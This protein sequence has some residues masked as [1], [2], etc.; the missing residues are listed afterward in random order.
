MRVVLDTNVLVSTLIA[1]SGAPATIYGLW[2]DRKFT[3]LISAEQIEEL[4]AVLK[5]PKV[6]MLMKPYTAGSLV[7]QL[8]RLA[9]MVDELPRVDRSPDP[10]DD[11]L[12]ALCEAGDADYL[13]TGDKRGLL[14]LKR[15]GKTRVVPP[16]IFLSLISH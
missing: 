12:L 11:Y 1:S 5:R 3:L 14:A 8:K 10:N 9:C 6:A 15:H 16:G 2:E 13:V 7:N 4:R